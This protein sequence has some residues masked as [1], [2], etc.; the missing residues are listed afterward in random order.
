MSRLN[1]ESGALKTGLQEAVYKVSAT[2]GWAS[3]MSRLRIRDKEGPHRVCT[4]H[5]PVTK[6]SYAYHCVY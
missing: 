1:L 6:V 5:S 2:E 4:I 3:D